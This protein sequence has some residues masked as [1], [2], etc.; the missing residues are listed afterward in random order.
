M[1]LQQRRA[2]LTALMLCAFNAVAL[3]CDSNI[4]L[5]NKLLTEIAVKDKTL[6]VM[7]PQFFGFN[8]ELAEFENSLW[9]ATKNKVDDK[10]AKY[11][12]RFPGAVYRYPGGAQANYFDWKA[13]VGPAL[14]RPA[15]QI[16]DYQTARSVQFGPAEYLGFV[17]EVKGTPWMVVN[18]FGALP[19]AIS[20]DAMAGS[21]AEMAAFFEQQ[22]IGG[23]PR[24]FRWELGNELDRGKIK[25]SPAR[26]SSVAKT[27]ADAIG[28][29]YKDAQFV[30]MAQD[31]QQTG[32][33]GNDESFNTYVG[34]ELKRTTKE[35]AGHLYYDG[36][37]WGPPTPTVLR[38]MCKNIKELAGDGFSD[39]MWITE[40]GRT[41]IGTPDDPNWKK[42]WPQTAN[43]AAAISV[44][45]VMISLARNENV[46][47]AFVHSLH[48]TSGPWPMFH[49]ATDGAFYPSAVYW[50][51]A[52]LREV[53]LE[54]VLD[55]TLTTP[56][57]G[58]TQ[59]PYDVNAALFST[60]DRSRFSGWLV[61]RGSGDAT[62]KINS[63]AMA[64]KKVTL[65]L[66]ELTG[67]NLNVS[68]YVDQYSLL[69]KQR[70][71]QQNVNANG[72]LT[73]TLQRYSVTALKIEGAAQ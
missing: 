34:R 39:S 67:A 38:Q 8:L 6:R 19:D 70:T 43:L 24:I 33:K 69:P 71:E 60:Q 51:L 40:H 50:S 68:N 9:D 47:G 16:A 31:W 52:A 42:N 32:T 10:I 46:N 25:W 23:M 61:N 11:L 48:G 73:I 56:D 59:I 35:F 1:K 41:P 28:G 65:T 4:Q 36:A 14:L 29:N 5:S 3:G 27:V 45:D 7:T 66:T 21:A 15:Q 44:A 26:Y 30:G 49:K 72:D 55:T 17:K 58:S 20:V 37:P 2:V 64:G 53:A 18:L 22:A 62:V 57:T 63:P 13:A 54:H 12:Q